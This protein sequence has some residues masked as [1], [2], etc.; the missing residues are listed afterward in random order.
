MSWHIYDNKSIIRESLASVKKKSD[1]FIMDII[2][3]NDSFM[4]TEDDDFVVGQNFLTIIT[5]V[6]N[7]GVLIDII[8]ADKIESIRLKSYKNIDNVAK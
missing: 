7:D 8:N 3:E 6:E 5:E 2:T 1:C 4:V